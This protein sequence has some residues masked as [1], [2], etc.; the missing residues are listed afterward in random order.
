[1]SLLCC[2][3]Q[4]NP[5]PNIKISQG[6]RIYSSIAI[7]YSSIEISMFWHSQILHPIIPL[8]IPLIYHQ[9]NWFSIIIDHWDYTSKYNW[10]LQ[11]VGGCT[12]CSWKMITCTTTYLPI[13]LLIIFFSNPSLSS[14]ISHQNCASLSGL[15]LPCLLLIYIKNA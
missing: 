5:S 8:H 3:K 4:G 10:T 7:D 2:L 12:I 13:H 14:P 15:V 11:T 1:M 6:P 9:S